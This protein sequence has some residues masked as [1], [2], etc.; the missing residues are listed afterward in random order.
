MASVS[1][2]V[3]AT[4]AGFRWRRS[5][6]STPGGDAV[7]TVALASGELNFTNV[8][9]ASNVYRNARFNGISGV[10]ANDFRSGRFTGVS[11][12][13]GEQVR[14]AGLVRGQMPISP[15]G[16][17]T[18]F[19]DRAATHIPQGNALTRGSLRISNPIRRHGYRFPSRRG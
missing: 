14:E 4:S 2:S 19:S 17:N 12:V 6:S 3:L 13:S 11:R 8:N 5:K 15:T 1:A 16:A 10:S 18:R 7:S 9:I